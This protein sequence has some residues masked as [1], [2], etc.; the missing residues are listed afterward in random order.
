MSENMLK[1]NNK[2]KYGSGDDQSLADESWE[3]GLII[4]YATKNVKLTKFDHLASSYHS[5]CSPASP[6]YCVK[7]EYFFQF[8]VVL[9]INAKK[10]GNFEC[11]VAFPKFG[12]CWNSDFF[13]ATSHRSIFLWWLLLL[14][15][16][17]I[18]FHKSC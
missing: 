4:T 8:S 18:H 5:Y 15:F 14:I 2:R 12:E 3:G 7:I 1:S 16:P 10:I 17:L 9:E 11:I 13:H 6:P